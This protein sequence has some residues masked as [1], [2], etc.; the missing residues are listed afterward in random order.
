MKA[1]KWPLACLRVQPTAGPHAHYSAA[2]SRAA[3]TWARGSRM[4]GVWPFSQL[5]K[6]EAL[7][8]FN[9]LWMH[10][11]WGT[12][13]TPRLMSRSLFIDVAAKQ[14]VVT[15][16]IPQGFYLH[17]IHVRLHTTI[18]LKYTLDRLPDIPLVWHRRWALL[19]FSPI[20][21]HFGRR[22]CLLVGD[23]IIF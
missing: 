4:A 5:C 22:G 1:R 18:L 3:E 6:A 20:M 16:R 21:P 19:F 12:N 17:A 7:K 15:G 2:G 13:T 14:D 23:V 11:C 8:G 10:T 9:K